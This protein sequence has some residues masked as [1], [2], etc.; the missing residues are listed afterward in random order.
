MNS[1]P[2]S[3]SRAI[4]CEVL[5]ICISDTHPSCMRAPPEAEITSS[6]VRVSSASSAAR[7]IDSP[8]APPIEPPMNEKSMP[9]TTIGRP[10]IVPVP[11]S[12]PVLV[13][14]FFCACAIRS[15]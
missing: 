5:T 11:C 12:A 10:S 13:S 3:A 15:T 1:T 7:V 9:A 8:T 2:S 4:A 14:L 6:G